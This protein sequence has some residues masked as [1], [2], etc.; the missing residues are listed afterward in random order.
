MARQPD[1]HLT[2]SAASANDVTAC[3]SSCL[4]RVTGTHI[5]PIYLPSKFFPSQHQPFLKKSAINTSPQ[6]SHHKISHNHQIENQTTMPLVVPGLQSKD[7]QGQDLTTEWLNKLTGKKIGETSNETV[8][9]PF[10]TEP[11][12]LWV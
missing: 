3:H 2:A 12:S 9:I 7:G 1:S 6:S 8:R 4:A 11:S 5:S 10:P